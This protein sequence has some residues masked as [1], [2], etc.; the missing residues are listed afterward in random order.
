MER[1]L[2]QRNVYE[3]KLINCIYLVCLAKSLYYVFL[4]MSR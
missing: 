2:K 4:E 3:Q 1:I